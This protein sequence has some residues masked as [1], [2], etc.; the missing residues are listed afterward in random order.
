MFVNKS[1]KMKKIL[2]I[3]LLTIPF[4]GF[5][6]DIENSIWKLTDDDGF[7]QIV[8]LKV[9]GS[10]EGISDIYG[11]PV[12][13]ESEISGEEKWELKGETIILMFNDKYMIKTGKIR[14]GRISGNY[15]TINGLSGTWIGER[16]N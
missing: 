3:F 14:G 12:M 15:I 2:F 4:I 11:S 9:D 6:Q 16:I 8:F 13:Y 10:F 7:G 1:I 5:G